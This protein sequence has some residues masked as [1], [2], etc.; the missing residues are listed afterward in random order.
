M[1]FRAVLG[2]LV[3]G[4]ALYSAAR[5]RSPSVPSFA[6]DWVL[7]A[8]KSTLPQSSPLPDRVEL[9]VTLETNRIGC[10]WRFAS[11]SGGATLTLNFTT[12]GTPS[13]IRSTGKE[14]ALSSLVVPGQS[15]PNP[16]DVEISSKWVGRELKVLT[17]WMNRSKLGYELDDVWRLSA[18][19]N[20]LTMDRISVGPD[21]S[22][23][24]TGETHAILVFERA[25]N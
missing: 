17:H 13:W 23:G 3:L 14:I 20:T 5:S 22:T 6:G 8:Q 25:K 10:E 16:G 2:A 4:L 24:R 21:A 7:N 15:Q 9:N 1:S 11:R 12:G 18:D 19:G